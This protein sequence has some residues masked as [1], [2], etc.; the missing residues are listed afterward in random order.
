MKKIP[1]YLLLAGIALVSCQKE[2]HSPTTTNF[3]PG[4]K[5]TLNTKT[6]VDR[7][8]SWI[9]KGLLFNT[10]LGGFSN[11]VHIQAAST[12]VEKTP[13]QIIDDQA[14]IDLSY[15]FAL[16]HEDSINANFNPNDYDANGLFGFTCNL[17]YSSAKSFTTYV[18]IPDV[19]TVDVNLQHIIVPHRIKEIQ[20]DSATAYF[21]DS[22]GD[23]DSMLIDYEDPPT[24]LYYI[25]IVNYDQY[26]T[27]DKDPKELC[28][29]TEICNGNGICEPQC[30]E[31]EFN[32]SDCDSVT[33]TNPTGHVVTNYRL[34][35]NDITI[36]D[37]SPY[38]EKWISGKYE[39]FYHYLVFDHNTNEVWDDY[40]RMGI[41]ISG[42]ELITLK[43]D[44]VGRVNKSGTRKNSVTTHTVNRLVTEKFHEGL[45]LFIAIYEL[46]R[47]IDIGADDVS[48]EI[49]GL[50][51]TPSDPTP[52]E[53]YFQTQRNK[54]AI[55]SKGSI[56]RPGYTGTSMTISSSDPAYI[57]NASEI[58]NDPGKQMTL[59]N[60]EITVTLEAK[61]F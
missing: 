34:Y 6:E 20:K 31:D 61:P 27:V 25:W 41:H 10:K 16:A 7:H 46:D 32:C 45:S 21:L 43:R 49:T 35:I 12:P 53:Y 9:A 39:M 18:E 26:A 48:V 1:F 52:F 44:Q 54:V 56:T 28:S 60:G 5:L 4:K 51:P 29:E 57:I 33:T 8:I 3:P 59:S 38:M 42:N 30:G 36:D 14:N 50:Q 37:T 17:W 13:V 55:V 24:H 58:L 19:H 15:P 22:S 40:Q 47:S 23:V 2:E 11:M